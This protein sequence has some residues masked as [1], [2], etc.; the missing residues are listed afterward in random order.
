MTRVVIFNLIA[1]VAG[2]LV[3]KS[4]GRSPVFWGLLSFFFPFALIIVFFLPAVLAVQ[5]GK[6]CANCR[7]AIPKDAVLCPYCGNQQPIEM[8]ECPNCRSFVQR[9]RNCPNCG[10]AL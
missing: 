5:S 3:A 2:G 6:Q 10:R 9:N 7:R 1:G 8:I 4:K